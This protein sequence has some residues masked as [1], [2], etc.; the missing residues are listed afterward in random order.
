MNEKTRTKYPVNEKTK[1]KTKAP[2]RKS[3]RS[4]L[5]LKWRYLMR[6]FKQQKS[7][8]CTAHDGSLVVRI[9]FSVSAPENIKSKN[10]FTTDKIE[11]YFAANSTIA[12]II[13]NLEIRYKLSNTKSRSFAIKIE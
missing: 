13:M 6:T 7:K 12:R 3:K 11:R 4:N 5:F 2:D 8:T 9:N 1:I 10:I